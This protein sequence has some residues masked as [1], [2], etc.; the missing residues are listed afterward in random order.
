MIDSN[1][2]LLVESL[3]F[4]LKVDGLKVS[5]SKEQLLDATIRANNYL[6][7]IV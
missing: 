7:K 5:I 6:K 3:T 4:V 2:F 1:E